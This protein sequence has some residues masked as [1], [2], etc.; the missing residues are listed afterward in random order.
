MIIDLCPL[1]HIFIVICFSVHY[2]D[3]GVC[4]RDFSCDTEAA[5]HNGLLISGVAAAVGF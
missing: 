3:M 5:A 4:I 2:V 1:V